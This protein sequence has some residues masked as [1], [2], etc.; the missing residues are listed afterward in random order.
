MINGYRNTVK[1]VFFWIYKIY[2]Y[3]VQVSFIENE[4]SFSGYSLITI[5]YI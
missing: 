3:I 5:K 4:C 2:H 1:M